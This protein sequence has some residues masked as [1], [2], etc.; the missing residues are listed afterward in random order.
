MKDGLNAFVYSDDDRELIEEA[1]KT[2]RPWDSPLVKD[3]KDR[4]KNFHMAFGDELCCYCYRDLH[5][6]FKLDI[7]TEH[8][9]P[10]RHYKGL[11]FDIRNLSVACKRCNMQMKR[12]NLDF[13]NL[14]FVDE[15]IENGQ[16]Y[17]LIHPNIDV[18]NDH[19]V[20]LAAQA[21]AIRV[22][23]YVIKPG[24]EKGKFAYDYFKLS[25]LE[26]DSFDE[27]QGA[28]VTSDADDGT[29]SK[30]RSIVKAIE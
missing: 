9:A 14:P 2:A 27:A 24:S 23:K 25:E 13:L 20:R 10:K 30:V 12:D 15:D 11:I 29:I 18:R 16:K 4:I 7:D 8:I 21:N 1:L 28:N 17:K 6:E 3:V 19:L 5:G 26:I 22:T